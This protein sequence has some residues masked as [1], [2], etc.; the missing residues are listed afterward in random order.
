MGW[1]FK[2]GQTKAELIAQRVERQENEFGTWETVAYSVK[3]NHLWKAKHF[4]NKETGI[5]DKYIAL[6]LI[7]SDKGY[8]YGYKDLTEH[9]GPHYYD[10]PLKYLDIIPEPQDQCSIEWRKKVREYHA[11][12][13]RKFIVGQVIKLKNCKIPEVEVVSVKPLVGFYNGL[14]YKVS[15]KLI[16]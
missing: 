8:G 12:M 4:Y 7:S 14:A 13:N 10:C 11:K 6:D 15:K 5:H 2:Q 16:A 9:E 3:G 1:S